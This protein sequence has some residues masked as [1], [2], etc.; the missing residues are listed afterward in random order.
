M[1]NPNDTSGNE[2]SHESG[3]TEAEHWKTKTDPETMFAG[4]KYLRN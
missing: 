2:T 3:E 1:V 4:E